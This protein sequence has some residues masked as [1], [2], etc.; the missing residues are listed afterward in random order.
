VIQDRTSAVPKAF[1]ELTLR[2]SD[3]LKVAF[4]TFYQVYSCIRFFEWQD[5]ESVIFLASFVVKKV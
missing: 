1:N 3:A 4:F 5:M 2:L